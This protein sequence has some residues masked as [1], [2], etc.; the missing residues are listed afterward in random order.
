MKSGCRRPRAG[1]ARAPVLAPHRQAARPPASRSAIVSGGRRGDGAPTPRTRARPSSPGRAD[2]RIR[3]ARRRPRGCR[4]ARSAGSA[5]CRSSK[6]TAI[7]VSAASP[8]PAD[9][10]AQLAPDLA[11]G[12]VAGSRRGAEHDL[13]GGLDRPQALGA[14][15]RGGDDAVG[16]G[17]RE[18][19]RG[20]RVRAALAVGQAAPP[21]HAGT[22]P[23]GERRQ[24]PRL[25]RARLGEHERRRGGALRAHA[26][27]LVAE[28]GQLPLPAHEKR[29]RVSAGRAALSPAASQSSSNALFLFTAS[30]SS[31]R[32]STACSVARKVPASTTIAPGSAAPWTRGAVFITSPI[33]SVSPSATQG[34]TSASPVATPM[35][36]SSAS[37]ASAAV[38]S[39]TPFR[40]AKAARSARS[41]SSSLAIGAPK[42][43]TTASPMNF[44]TVP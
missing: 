30:G 37:Q 28:R 35:R 16:A 19:L 44:S 4:R 11:H 42:S 10:P 21:E 5:Q 24:Q 39:A 17:G 33:A 20:G 26:S 3:T 29:V 32:Y 34:R 12:A 7:G 40:T 2:P 22:E 9:A 25:A 13:E 1:S 27:P 6:T 43:A 31:A 14:S 38:S 8:S 15:S 23:F 18:D 36:T 41:G